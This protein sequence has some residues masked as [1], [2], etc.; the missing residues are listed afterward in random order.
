ME[1]LSLAD[2]IILHF[3]KCAIDDT[4]GMFEITP[5]EL[6]DQTLEELAFSEADQGLIDQEAILELANAYEP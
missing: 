5:A 3:I 2:R 6:L 4:D 1:N